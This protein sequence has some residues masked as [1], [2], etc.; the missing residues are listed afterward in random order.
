MVA[1]FDD[2]GYLRIVDRTKDM[3]ITGGENV[4][5]REIEAFLFDMPG[6]MDVQVVGVP[7]S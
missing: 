3:I 1:V 7:S 5:P 2:E 6:I 4:Y